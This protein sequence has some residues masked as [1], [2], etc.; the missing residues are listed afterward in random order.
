MKKLVL[1]VLFFVSLNLF[2]QTLV[3]KTSV[4]LPKNYNK[5][6]LVSATMVDGNQLE[7]TLAVKKKKEL[8]VLRYLYDPSTNKFEEKEIDFNLYKTEVAV[9]PNTEGEERLQRFVRVD[10]SSFWQQLEIQ[11]GY[12][13]RHNQEYGA[14]YD[15]FVKEEVYTVKTDD[16]RKIIPFLTMHSEDNPVSTKD[17]GIQAFGYAPAGNLLVLGSVF[18]KLMNSTRDGVDGLDYCLVKVNSK[19]LSVEKKTIV[20]FDYIQKTE[21]S[22]VTLGKRMILVTTDNPF[23]YKGQEQYHIKG[24]TK[25]TITIFNVDGDVE[26]QYSFDGLPDMEVL[27][28]QEMENGNIYMIGRIDKNKEKKLVTIKIAN[29][30]LAYITPNDLSDIKSIAIKPANQKK[31]PLFSGHFFELT[32]KSRSFKGM[33]EVGNQLVAVYQQEGITYLQFDEQGRLVRQYN[34]AVVEDF[35]ASDGKNWRSIDMFIGNVNHD[36]QVFYPFIVEKVEKGSY[37]RVAKIDLKNG[38]IGNLISYGTKESGE[39]TDYYLD[40]LY[41]YILASNN[42]FI[43]IGRSKN[44]KNLWVNT[45]KFE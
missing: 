36:A 25:R 37:F 43:M 17:F 1:L 33:L 7:L 23:T 10:K 3:N 19:T 30:Q 27:S 13:L 44:K 21:F 26:S 41:P 14:F 9:L 5:G 2:S 39:E 6:K 29:K 18:P 15:E 35:T 34:N 16:G 22:S 11:K 32:N 8:E 42:Q 31:T 45:I 24:S 20:K 40:Q 12:I 28:A 38:T 4:E